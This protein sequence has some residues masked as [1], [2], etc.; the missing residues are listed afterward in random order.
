MYEHESAAGILSREL[1]GAVHTP[2]TPGYDTHR[3]TL[4]PA[5]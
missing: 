4:N 3:V 1:R 5:A 2:G